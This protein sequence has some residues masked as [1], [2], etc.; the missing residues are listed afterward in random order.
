MTA[1]NN[2]PS[3]DNA[4]KKADGRIVGGAILILIGG[5][6]LAQQWL[7]LNWSGLLVPGGLGLIFLDV[8]RAAEAVSKIV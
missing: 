5:L 8:K 4:P 3:T 7:N 1:N 2:Q 6:L